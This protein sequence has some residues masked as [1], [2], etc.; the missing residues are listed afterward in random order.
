[1]VY[2]VGSDQAPHAVSDNVYLTCGQPL[3]GRAR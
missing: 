3:V 2:E 1:M